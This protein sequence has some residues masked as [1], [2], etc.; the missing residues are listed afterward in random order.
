MGIEKLCCGTLVRSLEDVYILKKAG[1]ILNS[2]DG[3]LVELSFKSLWEEVNSVDFVFRDLCEEI[4]NY[5]IPVWKWRR[6]KGCTNITWYRWKESIKDLRQDYFKNRWSFVA[7][8]AASFVILLAVVQTF[9][10]VR[11]YYPR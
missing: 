7:F 3:F 10:T 4:N 5:K 9:Y 8:L 2:N 6:V 11:A 1:I